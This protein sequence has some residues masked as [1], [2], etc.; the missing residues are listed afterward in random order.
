MEEKLYVALCIVVL[1]YPLL[2]VGVRIIE[3]ALSKRYNEHSARLMRRAILILGVSI[4]TIDLLREFGLKLTAVL[5]SAG[6]AG[7]ALGFAL[8]TSVSN[9]ISGL[10]VSME[11][12]FAVGDFIEIDGHKGIVV[13]FDLLSIKICSPGNNFIRIPNEQVLKS[14]VI[15]HSKYPT[16]RIFL[17]LQFPYSWKHDQVYA[18]VNS[19]VTN[20]SFCLKEP[21]YSVKFANFTDSAVS[22]VLCVWVNSKEYSQ[23]K[24]SIA[25]DLHQA[26]IEAGIDMPYPHTVLA[27]GANDTAFRVEVFSGNGSQREKEAENE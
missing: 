22:C 13:S 3:K 24:N 21:P 19:V 7:V 16:K 6:I 20:N 2:F 11:V 25:S 26:F 9:I 10:F 4:L 14:S 5:G 1:G 8:K 17:P 12:P 15:N 23:A 27:N 18:V